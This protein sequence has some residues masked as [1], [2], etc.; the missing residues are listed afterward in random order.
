M[1]QIVIHIQNKK[2]ANVLLELLN[3]LDFIDLL[4]VS[5]Q[6]DDD[7]KMES[8]E[9]REDFFSLAGLWSGRDISVASIRKKAWP[10]RYDTK[11]LFS[12]NRTGDNHA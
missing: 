2:K 4:S 5:G 3:E 11:R 6:K 8:P 7:E 10:R 12:D 9:K 1:Q